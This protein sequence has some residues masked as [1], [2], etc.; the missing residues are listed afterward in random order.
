MYTTNTDNDF[1]YNRE[2]QKMRYLMEE[3]SGK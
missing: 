2:F 1:A 3:P